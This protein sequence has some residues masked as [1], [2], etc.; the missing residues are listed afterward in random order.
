[1]IKEEDW[2]LK[3]SLVQHMC[4]PRFH[5]DSKKD[6]KK[7]MACKKNRNVHVTSPSAVNALSNNSISGLFSSSLYKIETTSKR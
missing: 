7:K 3:E 2:M 4:K 1:M 5:G 6:Q